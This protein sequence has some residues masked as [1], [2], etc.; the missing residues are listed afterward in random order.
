[1]SIKFKVWMWLR[2]WFALDLEPFDGNDSVI[3]WILKT[4][5]AVNA[6]LLSSLSGGS[7]SAALV[8][9][10]SFASMLEF[11]LSIFYFI[12]LIMYGCY[13]FQRNVRLLITEEIDFKCGRIFFFLI[14]K[15][16]RFLNSEV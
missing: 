11:S 1:M 2:W 5:G 4:N 16:G 15:C 8:T 13:F 10:P 7:T 9:C 3:T 14:G 6:K 12:A